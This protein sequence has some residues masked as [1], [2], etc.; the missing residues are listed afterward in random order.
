MGEP[1]LLKIPEFRI[2]ELLDYFPP[3]PDPPPTRYTLGA[4]RAA[5]GTQ[6]R[7]SLEFR[8][9]CVVWVA[10]YDATFLSARILTIR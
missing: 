6:G 7:H 9:C 4:S 3:S 5:S 2:A 8:R 10:T 1:W